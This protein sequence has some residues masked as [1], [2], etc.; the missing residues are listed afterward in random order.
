MN[1]LEQESKPFLERRQQ[2]LRGCVEQAVMRYLHDLDG[3]AAANLHGLVMN[4]VEQPLLAVVLRH[5]KGNQ[6]QAAQLLGINRAT[7]RKKLAEYGLD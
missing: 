4:E 7:L 2:P 1:S 3:M 6:T 5:T